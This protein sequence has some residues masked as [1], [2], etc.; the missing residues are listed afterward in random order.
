KTCLAFSNKIRDACLYVRNY[1]IELYPGFG[2][3]DLFFDLQ[4]LVQ[5][6]DH[7]V[8]FSGCGGDPAHDDVT[9]FF[10]EW[11]IKHGNKPE[12]CYERT[13]YIVGNDVTELLK[14]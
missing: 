2:L 7:I 14:S 3:R 13:P 12:N 5:V 4:D 11:H 6:L 9:I 10:I 1:V 8:K